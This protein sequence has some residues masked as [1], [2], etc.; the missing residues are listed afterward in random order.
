MLSISRQ[1]LQRLPLYLNYLKSLPAEVVNISATT[2]AQAL[3]MG[4]VQVRKDLAS[5]SSGGRPKVGY[6]TRRLIHDISEFLG[7]SNTDSAV[8]AGAGNMGRALL[9][10]QGF[11]E[12]GV[13]IVAAFDSDYTRQGVL[14]NGKQIFPISRLSE[15]CSR[16]QVKIGIIAVPAQAAQQVCDTM[17][18]AGVLAIWNFAPVHLR[19]PEGV[20]VQNEN[21]AVSLAILCQHLQEKLWEE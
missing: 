2:M 20:L 7:Y 9:S 8:L 17:I 18:E 3:G 4:D 13:D 14:E 6:E 15:L 21:M 19:V 12:C 1:T 16:M 11:A 10:Y 5:V